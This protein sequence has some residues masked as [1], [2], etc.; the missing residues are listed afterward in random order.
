MLFSTRHI[1]RNLR[2][3]LAYSS[4]EDKV[5]NIPFRLVYIFIGVTCFTA[6]GN[7]INLWFFELIFSYHYCTISHKDA[8][9]SAFSAPRICQ[10]RWKGLR[11]SASKTVIC[12]LESCRSRSTKNTSLLS[13]RVNHRTFS[14]H[15]SIHR[16]EWC[17]VMLLI[18]IMLPCSG[19]ENTWHKPSGNSHDATNLI[20][21]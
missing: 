7:S 6:I 19:D 5:R 20:I 13:Q 10:L 9:I 14:L 4:S 16:D 8:S 15:V 1:Y 2:N 12:Y 17:C 21:I 3:E 18:S 11:S